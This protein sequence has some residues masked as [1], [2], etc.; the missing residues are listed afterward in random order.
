M[1]SVTAKR[2]G[3]PVKGGSKHDSFSQ[4]SWAIEI[5]HLNEEEKLFIE[6]F[7]PESRLVNRSS[8]S[9]FN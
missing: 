3:M 1:G 2:P 7:S 6:W 4:E 5:F 8:R 9:I